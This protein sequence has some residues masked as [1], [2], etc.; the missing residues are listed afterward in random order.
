MNCASKQ[1]RIEQSIVNGDFETVFTDLV[2]EGY[3]INSTFIVNFGNETF[4]NYA[5]KKKRTKLAKFLI[6]KGADPNLK[7]GRDDTPLNLAIFFKELEIAK[8]LVTKA[9]LKLKD[10]DGKT[11]I[12]TA[13][14][15]SNPNL[16]ILE[17]LFSNGAD[18]ND[19]DNKQNNCLHLIIVNQAK[20]KKEIFNYLLAKGAKFDVPN[21]SGEYPIHLA[22]RYDFTND[23]TYFVSELVKRGDKI[24]KAENNSVGLTVAH[25]AVSENCPNIL[26]IYISKKGNL[27][28]KLKSSG[29]TP[30]MLAVF[31]R[32]Y[33]LSK[34]LVSKGAKVNEVDLDGNTALSIAIHRGESNIAKLLKENGAR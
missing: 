22:T 31:W 16:E 25:I 32:N 19:L 15:S 27:N 2:N 1:E 21:S 33:R 4:L 20:N 14:D 17:L 34:V 9:N 26:D 11:P 10:K 8:I 13:T 7:D 5:I 29:E 12:L 23:D 6:E 3:P 30:L 28:T 24:D 18:I